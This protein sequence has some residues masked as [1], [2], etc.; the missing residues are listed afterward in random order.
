M[1]W[2][3]QRHYKD[4]GCSHIKAMN[5]SGRRENVCLTLKYPHHYIILL[6]KDVSAENSEEGSFMDYLPQ[7][8]SY[9]NRV[10]HC[11]LC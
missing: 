1:S 8:A 7:R 2:F 5:D 6:D 3:V 9:L 10:Q 11:L 4:A